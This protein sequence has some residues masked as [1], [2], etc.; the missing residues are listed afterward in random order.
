MRAPWRWR[1][2]RILRLCIQATAWH[3]AIQWSPFFTIPLAIWLVLQIRA[4]A[5]EPLPSPTRGDA[6]EDKTAGHT[7]EV[8]F[9]GAQTTYTPDV[10]GSRS[11]KG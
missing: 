4:G 10:T 7:R 5:T 11:G 9:N 6:Y 2:G 8:K 3:L 1:W